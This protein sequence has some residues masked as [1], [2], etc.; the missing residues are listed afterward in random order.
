MIP[1]PDIDPVLLS[2][3][4]LQVRWYGLM[5]L[6][7]FTASYVLVKRQ[8]RACSFQTLGKQFE[9]LNVV[10]ILS[11]II[12][13][14]LG[15]VAFYNLPYYLA[16]PWEIP[17]TWT[18]GMSF[19]GAAIGLVLGGLFFCRR[20]GIDFFAAADLYVATIPI[21]LGLGRIGNFINGELF[22]RATDLPWGM[23]FPDGGPVARH[24]SQLYE[25]LLEGLVLFTILWTLRY[26]PWQN[27]RHWPHGSLLA[28]FFCLYGLFR[29]L[30]E[31]VREPDPQLGLFFGMVTM[32]QLLS[33]TMIAGGLALWLWLRYRRPTP[34]S[35]TVA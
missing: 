35:P 3:G 22:G 5:Y 26:R 4:P 18:G 19:H 31:F 27:R 16:H 21:G 17:A 15:Y 20:T 10:L 8:I 23:V 11:V 2:I 9:N 12:G 6:L 32:G 28:L 33:S 30:V 24:P 29:F 14:R 1:Y 34:P 13:G 25:A 7:G